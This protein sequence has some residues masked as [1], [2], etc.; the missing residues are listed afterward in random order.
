[1]AESQSNL[2]PEG[3][4]LIETSSSTVGSSSIRSIS[5]GGIT[6]HVEPSTLE[7]P[8][9][10]STG[11]IL[12]LNIPRSST[13][14]A[15]SSSTP[16]P[17]QEP[18]IVMVAPAP[19][20]K[21]IRAQIV[22]KRIRRWTMFLVV[23]I[24]LA[25]HP[26]GAFTYDHLRMEDA[27]ASQTKID[28][29]LIC[30]CFWNVTVDMFL[31]KSRSKCT[32]CS[33]G[34]KWTKIRVRRSIQ[35]VHGNTVD[36]SLIRTRHIRGVHH[37]IPVRCNLCTIIWYP[38]INNLVNHATRCGNCTGNMPLNLEM[39]IMRIHKIHGT[40][41]HDLSEIK[42]EHIN[43]FLSMIPVRC[44]ICNCKAWPKIRN[45]IYNKTACVNCSGVVPITYTV[46]FGTSVVS[47]W[48]SI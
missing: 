10:R 46:F 42:P 16:V 32:S 47:P 6:L 26:Q 18:E 14:G 31:G 43:G 24:A 5:A 40:E 33:G 41:R 19:D 8:P 1:M 34:V 15:A 25:L 21:A 12:T 2:P 38:S 17:I 44:R 4:E 30:R 20:P 35:R 7:M 48:D 23:Q 22:G 45:I 27:V 29:G 37:D 39:V 13:S 36:S 28:L 11:R 3:L 9:R